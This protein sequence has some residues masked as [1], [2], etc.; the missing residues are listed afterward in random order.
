MNGST[1]Y[2]T[3]IG[4][5]CLLFLVAWWGDGR[6]RRF[7]SGRT[8]ALVY[9]LS[10][11]VYCTSWTYYGS[12][13]LASLHGLDFLPIYIGPILVIGFASRLVRRIVSIARAQ[14]LTTVAD[15]V[16]ARYGKS[17]GVGAIA[18]LI[19]LAASTPYL[20]LQLKA[21]AE[22]VSTVVASF[23]SAHLTLGAPSAT[24]Y[25]AIALMLAVFAMAFGTR[26]IDPTEH[27]DG[28]ILAIA[29]ESIVKLVAF[30][31]VGAF[32]LW[33]LNGGLSDLTRL[34]ATNPAIAKVVR[35]APDVTN[36][37]V[38]T[39]L[40]ASAI[41]LLPRQFHVTVVENHDPKDIRAAAWLFPLYLVL[42][43]L[44]VAPLA[45]AG[46]AAFPD[47]AVS[48][49]LT[50]L[51]LPLNAGALGVAL[52]TMIGGVSAAT[53]MVVVDSVAV[54]ITVSNDLVMPLI[55]RRDGGGA[56]AAAGES[57]ARVLLVRRMAIVA[58]LLLGFVYA[59]VASEAGLASIGLLSFTAIAQIAPAFLGG[60]LWRRGTARG[61]IAGMS[62]GSLLWL[63][64]LFL[65]S[66]EPG[67]AL[68]DLLGRGPLA[69]AWLRPDALVA[70]A[71]NPLAGGAILSLC[72]N[73]AAFVVFSLLR[74][75]SPLERM[76]AAVFVG[77][78]ASRKPQVFRLWRSSTTGG[79]L[80]TAVARYLGAARARRAFEGFM[81][82]RGSRF[83]PAN[84]ADAH[85]IRHAEHLLSPAIGASTSRL[86]LSLLLRP[87]AVS[88]KSALKLLDDA[89][90]AIQSSRDQLQHALDHA[91]QGITVFDANLGLTTWNREFADLFDLPS[92]LLRPGVGLDEIV[93]F[94]ASR[95]AYGPGD[96]EDFVAERI[97]SLL[98][99][100][101][102]HRLRLFSTQRVLEV[103]S[104]RLPDG[105]IVTTYT[106]VTETVRAEEELAASNERLERRV[107]ERTAELE[108]LNAA[109]ALAKTQ[110][111]DANLSK[112]R[113][114]AAASHDILQPL[115]A[116]RL[117]ASSLKEG[118][119][120]ANDSEHSELARKVDASLEAVEEILSALLDISRL[121]AGAT[122]PELSD[123]AVEDMLRQLEIEFAPIARA[124]GLKLQFAA[125]SLAVRSDRR[126]LRRL[127]QNLVSNA[128]KY[129]LN[130]RVLVGC[131]RV[132]DRVRFE[133]WD[134]G[135]GIPE[136]Q[137][138]VVFEEFRRLDQGARVARGLGLGLSIV[139]RLG[140]V[141]DHAIGLRSTPGAGSVFTV[142]APRGRPALRAAADAGAAEAPTPGETLRGLRVLAID[143][144]P[145]I[146]EGMQILLA[147]WGCE[148]AVAH[149][150]GEARQ[151]M[152]TF[153]ARAPEVIIAD[154]HLDEGD[155]VTA[156]IALR[157]ESGLPIPAI[158]A[159]ADRSPEVRAA[160]ERADVSIMNKPLKPAPLRAQLTRFSALRAAAE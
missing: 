27:Q 76:Q 93:R 58:V 141:L 128:L 12:V 130:G 72:V 18:A 106:D 67:D 116:A 121:D 126:L 24:F 81:G 148:V 94:N 157:E 22:T 46:L 1:V 104:A 155:G 40:S 6:G 100:D 159:T 45:I 142:L 122:R 35:T 26:R 54:S 140:R 119:A 17:Q 16:S 78:N 41:L 139:E 117:Y 97:E 86:V 82:E 114:L 62:A 124:K 19:A 5:V 52:L 99:D 57:G 71:P 23:D 145:R 2:L 110:A 156:I 149:D 36:W 151:A 15:F 109:L 13:G 118:A 102:P 48:R 56:S 135:L 68:G 9:A 43:N 39:L 108:N 73:V 31:V 84:E 21:I 158:L 89:S 83:D 63:Y 95:G 25:L 3:A 75:V 44:F 4:Y 134:T 123:F 47:G 79:E 129:T 14:N 60:L 69:I 147:K 37:G 154:Y 32:V 138:R 98:Y 8:R 152:K 153:A 133:I 55:L 103:R 38:T 146:L 136:A 112:T 34:A 28:L 11:A 64:L 92:A 50:V 160:A 10:L 101:Q 111:D 143:N 74:Q 105:G 7:V 49:D 20:A 87:R 90:A 132:G 96:S 53:G 131:R 61:A 150:L 85:L 125:S 77:A 127:L 65:P 59:R 29:A 107:Q 91:R 70:F 137:Q 88:G 144:E 80:E 51:A 113:F 115:N 30:L 120:E 66:M 33:G 42:I